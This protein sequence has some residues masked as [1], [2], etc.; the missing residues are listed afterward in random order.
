MHDH[1]ETNIPASVMGYTQEPFPDTLSE[2]SITLWGKNSPFRH[3]EVIRGWVEG[4]YIL[5]M[6]IDLYT[7]L[8]IQRVIVVGAS[9]SAF[10]ITHEVLRFA[11]APV[12]SSLQTP[13]PIFGYVP[14]EHPL[15]EKKP[16]ISHISLEGDKKIVF[17][18]DG[19]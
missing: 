17:F 3:R 6:N 12:Y 8:T 5:T 2:R 16:I 4:I 9:V 10:D 15:V 11:K 7:N 18:S 13:N 1:L 14:F 19:R